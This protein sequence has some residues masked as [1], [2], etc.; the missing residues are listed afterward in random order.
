MSSAEAHKTSDS[1]WEAQR[2]KLA[3]RWFFFRVEWAMLANEQAFWGA[4]SKC[5]IVL[6]D[7]SMT[8]CLL[9]LVTFLGALFGATMTEIE[10]D[11]LPSRYGFYSRYI[12]LYPL[13]V[14]LEQYTMRCL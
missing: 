3:M 10:G 6:Y 4:V 9:K 12:V 8:T 7:A 13:P 11:T 1:A 2:K 14:L 5:T